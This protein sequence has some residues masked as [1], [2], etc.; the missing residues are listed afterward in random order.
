LCEPPARAECPVEDLGRRLR[1][2]RE[3]EIDPRADAIG[4]G[5]Q[6]VEDARAV[7][8]GALLELLGALFDGF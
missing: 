1:G 2:E 7:H 4:Q 8:P 5:D 3:P 6:P